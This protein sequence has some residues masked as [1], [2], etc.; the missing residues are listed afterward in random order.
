MKPTIAASIFEQLKQVCIQ[1]LKVQ[2][3]PGSSKN[4]LQALT[5]V[6]KTRKIKT[7]EAAFWPSR[8]PT[9]SFAT[10]TA[11]DARGEIDF[12]IQRARAREQLGENHHSASCA[13]RG[14]ESSTSPPRNI[15][16][17]TCCYLACFFCVGRRD[18]NPLC[19]WQALN[20]SV[21]LPLLT[22][23]RSTPLTKAEITRILCCEKRMI[24]IYYS[25]S[26]C[27][28]KLAIWLLSQQRN[29]S[30]AQYVNNVF[31]LNL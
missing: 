12:L 1:V 24:H 23:S 7:A 15:S 2:R 9:D 3:E 8:L 26:S 14:K 16:T 4:R 17:C 30:N 10:D 20:Y 5:L 29:L 27:I 21:L 18:I 19:W 31:F 28:Q 13:R 6:H 25:F 11:A 22:P